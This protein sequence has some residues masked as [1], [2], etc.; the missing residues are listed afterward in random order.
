VTPDNDRNK[1]PLP[2]YRR[3]SFWLPFS[4]CL[5]IFLFLFA[6]RMELPGKM[7]SG[8]PALDPETVGR[9]EERSTW[10]TIYQGPE[11]IGYARKLFEKRVDGFR[12]SESVF[13]RINTMGMI[14]DLSIRTRGELKAD[15]SLSQFDFEIRSGRFSFSAAGKVRNHLLRVQTRSSGESR[16]FDIRLKRPLYMAAAALE[17]VN[18]YGLDIGEYYQIDVFDP[19][20][21][22]N[23]PA[24]ITIVSREE[25]TIDGRPFSTTKVMLT[26]KGAKQFAWID[27][28]G[29]VLREK[30]LLGIHMEKTEREEALADFSAD[31]AGDLTRMASVP[32][33]RVL[34]DVVALDSLSLTIGGIQTDDLHLDGGRQTL[35]DS[36]LTI[37]KE[38]LDD[39]AAVIRVEDLAVFE[40]IFLEASPLIQSDHPRIRQLTAEILADTGDVPLAR[41]KKLLG[42]VYRNI[43]KRPVVSVPDALSTLENRSGDC[44]EHAVLMAALARAA[45]IPARIE[46]GLVYLDGRFY[47]HAWNAFY[48]GRWITADAVFN[49]LPADVTHIRFASIAQQQIDLIG[50]IGNLELRIVAAEPQH[51]HPG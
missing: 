44:N 8:P 15:F 22:S 19:L 1:G 41:I 18:V 7:F 9:V 28:N 21:M 4:G 23:E 49:Q 5:M 51:A 25:I 35:Q 13:M 46:S 30:G 14:Q 39:L 27:E 38:S 16:S 12:M 45:G 20:T 37:Q 10:M 24:K 31:S 47:Y 43:D 34:M 40:K 2:V 48:L 32:S 50:L 42:W 17:T 11:K 6:F 33:D 3:R 36:V 29:E 26:F